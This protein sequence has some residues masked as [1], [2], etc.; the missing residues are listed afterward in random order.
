MLIYWCK[1][2]SMTSKE[3]VLNAIDHK[4]V[5]RVPADWAATAWVNDMMKKRYATNDMEEVL[6]KLE[7]DMRS[8]NVP[9]LGPSFSKEYLNKTDYVTEGIWGNKSKRIWTGIEYNSNSIEFPLDEESSLEDIMNHPFPDLDLFDYESVKEQC[10]RHEDKGLIFGHEG[11]YQI[12]CSLMC[13]DRVYL[14]MALHPDRM[15]ALYTRLH[16]WEIEKYTRVLEAGDGQIDIL[17]THDDYGTQI[18]TLFSMDM[19]R[20]FFYEN[21]KGLADL[22][23]KYGARFMQHSCGAVRPVIPELIRAGVDA[24]DPVQPTEGMDPESLA[25]EFGGKICFHGGIDTQHLLPYG[26]QDEVKKEVSRYI[27]NLNKEGGYILYPSQAWES[28]VPAENIEAL[29]A[30]RN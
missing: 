20:D 12:V 28:C 9:Y 10:R 4:P 27:G 7:I 22:A 14:N 18:S 13:D 5:D 15:K 19:W 23:H 8:I 1:E 17:R 29:Y 24:L 25:R 6:T 11:P 26:T 21:T 2:K 30:V 16:E 3:R